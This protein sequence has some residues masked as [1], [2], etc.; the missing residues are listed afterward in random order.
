MKHKRL[1]RVLIGMIMLSSF[2]FVGRVTGI[3]AQEAE[4]QPSKVMTVSVKA[5]QG[6]AQI[7]STVDME[8]QRDRARVLGIPAPEAWKPLSIGTILEQ[9]DR[10]RTDPDSTMELQL[11]DGTVVTLDN[12][13]VLEVEE[14]KSVRAKSLK[15]TRLFLE[16]G[17]IRTVQPTKI[18]GQTEQIIRTNNGT[19]NTRLGEVEVEKPEMQPLRLAAAPAFQWPLLAQNDR[20]RGDYT[21][22]V[23]NRGTADIQASGEGQMITMSFV[24]PESCID[25]DG[26][27][28]TLANAGS[29]VTL[30]KLEREAAFQ[31]LANEVFQLLAGTE[32]ICNSIT[33]NTRS[34]D[35]VIDIEGIDVAEL[36][37]NSSLVIAMHELLTLGYRGLDAQIRFECDPTESKG[38][39]ELAFS[40]IDGNVTILRDNLGAG[41]DASRPEPSRGSGIATY[42]TPTP[43][44]PVGTSTPTPT[45]TGTPTPTPT[46]T[47][48]ETPKE[49]PTPRLTP[50]IIPIF[51]TKPPST[52][53]RPAPGPTA[54][55]V[56]HTH[57]RNPQ[58]VGDINVTSD[59]NNCGGPDTYTITIEPYIENYLPSMVVAPGGQVT[60][61]VTDASWIPYS[62]LYFH[63]PDQV[64]IT[65]YSY[66]ATQL[67]KIRLNFSFCYGPPAALGTNLYFTLQVRDLEG[68]PSNVRQ[69]N[70][71][72]GVP[73]GGFTCP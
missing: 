15:M 5:I 34:Q 14:L 70:G 31:V 59:A 40:G 47:P 11:D 57:P 56:T 50:V 20:R 73:P 30:S 28:F 6:N 67:E 45:L 51:P 17:K 1:T 7:L 61:L 55:P 60:C 38:I 48:T 24:L 10:L 23:L 65:S 13:T 9:G 63:V 69:C 41:L 43:I 4:N 42:P 64:T 62:P 44:I 21:N 8:K 29:Q 19:V 35:G 12:D 3:Y 66:D 27:R 2:V 72:I 18:L 16:K 26:I 54:I 46:P 33:V 32:G 25:K 52:E 22:V 53:S 58:I 68:N 39:S 71:D 37:P 36:G 49:T